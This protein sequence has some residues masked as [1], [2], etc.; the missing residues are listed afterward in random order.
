VCLG[1]RVETKGL[2]AGTIAT[3]DA[4]RNS[5]GSA[6][7]LAHEMAVLAKFWNDLTVIIPKM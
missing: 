4:R 6:D 7:H 3:G 5:S 1:F 2:P